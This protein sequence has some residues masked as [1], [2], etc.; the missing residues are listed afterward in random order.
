LD[1]RVHDCDD[2]DDDNHHHHHNHDD[3]HKPAGARTGNENFIGGLCTPSAGPIEI[4]GYIAT[5]ANPTNM[6]PPITQYTMPKIA[7]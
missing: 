3:D 2:H 4:N 6:I 7:R 1:D 5:I